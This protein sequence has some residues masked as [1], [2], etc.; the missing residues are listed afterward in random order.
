MFMV[1]VLP[2]SGPAMTLNVTEK[3]EGRLLTAM[4]GISVEPGTMNGPFYTSTTR[5]PPR[6]SW[7][8]RPS[9][10]I[11]PPRWD[12]WRSTSSYLSRTGKTYLG[13]SRWSPCGVSASLAATRRKD[14]QG[15]LLV[16]PRT[17]SA[18]I[19]SSAYD[20]ARHSHAALH[21]IID[22]RNWKIEL[23][24]YACDFG[25]VLC[26]QKLLGDL[27]GHGND[28]VF[29]LHVRVAARSDPVCERFF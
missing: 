25:F 11:Q 27:I 9:S 29:T 15:L 2:R 21:A 20:G 14:V 26:F 23:P 3:L 1:P 12:G 18:M 7:C 6:S 4:L 22:P 24:D 19:P 28:K 10:S 16:R 8:A 13:S 5:F 17:A